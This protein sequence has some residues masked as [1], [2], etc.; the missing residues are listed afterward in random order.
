M[1]DC[2]LGENLLTS[3]HLLPADQSKHQ[4]WTPHPMLYSLSAHRSAAL[5]CHLHMFGQ[6]YCIMQSVLLQAL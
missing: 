2:L 3:G 6:V 5:I 4:Q 1:E